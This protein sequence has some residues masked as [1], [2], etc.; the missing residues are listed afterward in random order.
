MDVH[1][2]AEDVDTLDLNEINNYETATADLL[3]KALKQESESELGLLPE[4]QVLAADMHVK[5]V[6]KTNNKFHLN[7]LVEVLYLAESGVAD[8]A[9][10]LI[11]LTRQEQVE[12]AVLRDIYQIMGGTAESVVVNFEML[13]P[14]AT[15]L[16]ELEEHAHDAQKVDQTLIIACTCLC[17]AL[18]L[19]TSVLLYVAGGWRDLREKMEEQIDWIKNTRRTYSQ[20]EDDEESA[21]VDVADSQS[22][23]GDADDSAATNPNGILGASS[24]DNGVEGMGIHR[25]PERG[26]DE[27]GYETTPFSEISHYTDSSRAPL[28]ISSMRKM[29][30]DYENTL[31]PLAYQ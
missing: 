15:M 3:T 11:L 25:T 27:E 6:T 1:W 7:A 30:S 23:E 17:A 18:V 13:E 22:Y 20:D 31:P 10:I 29:N 19:V 9:S 16:W 12:Q 24:K 4:Q 2:E 26:M 28:G 5:N 8:M 21:G 14:P